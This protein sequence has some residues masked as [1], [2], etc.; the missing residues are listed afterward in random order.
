MKYLVLGP[1][2]QGAFAMLGYLKKIEDQLGDIEEISGASCGAMIAFLMCA[3]KTINQL[4]D[5]F[6]A[7]D[8]TP[9]NKLDLNNFL[10]TYGFVDT[11]YI[12]EHLIQCCDGR[13]PTFR[14][15]SKKLHVAAM[16]VSTGQTEYFSR[17][18]HPD[19]HVSEAVQ[20]SCSIPVMMSAHKFQGRLYAD[21]GILEQ[22]P[23]LPFLNKLH[24]DVLCVSV[25]GSR[26]QD[27]VIENFKDYLG[28]IING[29]VQSA[30]IRYDGLP[31]VTIRTGAFN[32]VDMAMVHEDKLKLFILGN[33]FP[34]IK[35]QDE[36]IVWPES[37]YKCDESG[38]N[39][40]IIDSSQCG[41]GEDQD[42][43]V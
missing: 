21:G 39:N 33:L 8:M 10:T 4:F 27:V 38:G 30:R 17:D 40:K 18:T 26:V 2:G 7:T 29:Y 25:K 12:R 1:G 34:C 35:Q 20:M 3:G 41:P 28:A 23:G 32:L 13:D 31:C 43:A 19:M 16:C 24:R 42:A 36:P 14:E 37:K 15:L 6:L 5:L 11:A 9:M 22:I